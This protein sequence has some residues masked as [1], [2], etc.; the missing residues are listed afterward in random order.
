MIKRAVPTI[1]TAAALISIPA[2]IASAAPGTGSF[3]GG[4]SVPT[5]SWGDFYSLAECNITGSTMKSNDSTIRTWNCVEG[6]DKAG[7]TYWRLFTYGY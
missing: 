3:G 2:A 5:D 1:L 4:N 6:V 7:Y